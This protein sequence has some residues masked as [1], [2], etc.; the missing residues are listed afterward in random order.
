MKADGCQLVVHKDWGLS[1]VLSRAPDCLSA[2]PDCPLWSECQRDQAGSSD[3]RNER[4]PPPLSQVSRKVIPAAS[5]WPFW[6][7]DGLS[8]MLAGKWAP[9][10][11]L[12][13][14]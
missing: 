7:M 14:H 12:Q 10:N 8:S 11:L 6:V 4:T 3:V 9:F 2:F 1:L 5:L 13:G